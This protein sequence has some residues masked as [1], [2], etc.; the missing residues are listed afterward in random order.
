MKIG[1]VFGL[2]CLLFLSAGVISRADGQ[3]LAISSVQVVT[4]LPP[5]NCLKYSKF[6]LLVA[7]TGVTAAKYYDPAPSFGGL[8][9][10]ARF[11]SPTGVQWIVCGFYDG[12]NWRVR[13]APNEAGTWQYTVAVVD[14]GGSATSPAGSFVCDPSSSLGWTRINGR[15]LRFAEGKTVFAVGHNTGWQYDVEQPPLS[16]MAAKGENLLSF[17]MATP[18]ATP[19]SYAN[20]APIENVT[21]GIGNYNQAACAYM[22]TVV[23]RAEAAGVYLLPTIWSHGQLRETGVPWPEGWWYNNAYTNLCSATDFFMTTTGANETPQWR[24]QKNFYRY[25]LARWGYSTAIAGWVAMCEMDGTTGFYRNKTQAEAWTVAM[26]E[27]FRA[28][29]LF[30]KNALG[31]SPVAFFK[32]DD[33]NWLSSFDL[34]S[35][36][37]YTSAT[38]NINVAYTIAAQTATMRASGRPCLHGEFGGDTVHGA[39]QPGHLHNGIWAGL[40]AGAAM[41]PLVW[42]DGG[43]YPMLTTPMQDHLQYLSQ[44]VGSLNYLDDT[45]LAPASLSFSPTSTRGWGLKIADRGFVWVQNTVGNI[46]GQTMTVSSLT[47]GDYTVNWFD[48]WTS[49]TTPTRTMASTVNANG[50]LSLQ[51]PSLSRADIACRFE[52]STP[53]ANR[54][55]VAVPDS[56][57]VSQNTM[58]SAK[59]PGV[60]SNDSD[61]DGNPITAVP[62]AVPSHGTLALN[63]NGSF[64][65]QPSTGYVGADTFT[66]RASDGQLTSSETTVTITVTAPVATPQIFGW[67]TNSASAGVKGIMVTLEKQVGGRWSLLGTATTDASGYYVFGNL[68]ASDVGVKYRVTPKTTGY[69]YSPKEWQVTLKTVAPTAECDFTAT[70]KKG[71]SSKLL[72]LQE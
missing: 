37:S 29:D 46:G 32:V 31:N 58:L 51:M 22:D 19:G 35:T 17:W 24:Y 71:V 33:P 55:P 12:A 38:S 66:Y 43:N 1:G 42:C 27:Y 40:T 39:S 9:L 41:T 63:S 30:R 52:R 70:S 62:A 25:L 72:G 7:L 56:Y 48:A 28:N 4:P 6:E 3:P 14:G 65:Y 5:A 36:D 16:A 60:L 54:A 20:R 11:T 10:S 13:F 26:Q 53:P 69:N 61:P 21:Q 15:Y 50:I 45:N 23:A 67:V 8:D 49:G 47:P 64:T 57:S 34:R 44:F 68:V 2:M 18:W 59:A